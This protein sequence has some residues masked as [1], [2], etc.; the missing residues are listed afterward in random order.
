MHINLVVQN[1][2][3]LFYIHVYFSGGPERAVQIDYTWSKE[4][5]VLFSVCSH[6]SVFVF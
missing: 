5:L 6:E 1:M 3:I 2:K 4:Q